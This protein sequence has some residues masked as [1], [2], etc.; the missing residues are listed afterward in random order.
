MTKDVLLATAQFPREEPFHL[1]K[2]LQEAPAK[3]DMIDNEF[4][5]G[6]ADLKPDLEAGLCACP[7]QWI[8][9]SASRDSAGKG[10]RR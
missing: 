6:E 10:L 3:P 7:R 8:R 5:I 2:L 9:E 4:G 1:R